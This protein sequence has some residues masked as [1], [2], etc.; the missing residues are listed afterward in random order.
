MMTKETK[1]LDAFSQKAFQDELQIV[2]LAIE[3]ELNTFLQYLKKELLPEQKLFD[4]IESRVKSQESFQEK[5]HRK[6]YLHIWQVEDDIK[7]NQRL[8]ATNL[9]DLIGFRINC[10]FWPDESKIYE[11]LEKYYAGH[12]FPNFTLDF[13]ENKKQKNGH[14][15]YKL[16]GKYT[17]PTDREKVYNFEI[18]IK[19]IM[20]NIWG[21]VDHKTV[22]KSRDYD[23]D[24]SS[25]K[26]ITEELFHILQASDKQL[27]TLLG[28]KNDE[29]RLIYALFY[30]QTKDHM[31]MKCG[32]D[33]LAAHYTAFFEF[34]EGHEQT[35]NC[36]REYVAH[37]LLT[38]QYTRKL[39]QKPV[40][41]EKLQTLQSYI[42]HKFYEY[43]LRCLFYIFDLLYSTTNAANSTE[44]EL[45]QNFLAHLSV[46]AIDF[47]GIG[48]DEAYEDDEDFDSDDTPSDET[49]CKDYTEDILRFLSERIVGQKND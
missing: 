23:A 37:S 6:D 20:H 49:D 1:L 16:T 28:R 41:S 11:I 26:T 36:I 39:L 48:N 4:N 8:I 43:N 18:Q 47:S 17:E 27:L 3:A 21:E 19:S 12:N 30:T 29:K 35:Y 31:I 34:F 7:A 15:I 32:T 46:W 13:S 45:F 10:F 9:P 14:I 25:K 40:L 38:M 2:R 5:I 44:E 33:I 22:F 24:C 42:V